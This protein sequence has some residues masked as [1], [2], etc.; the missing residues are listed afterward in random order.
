[1]RRRRI[2]QPSAVSARHRDALPC[3]GTAEQPPTAHRQSIAMPRQGIPMHRHSESNARALH[4]QATAKQGFA[5]ATRSA[6]PQG[7]RYARQ[8]RGKAMRGQDTAPPRLAMAKLR[9][10]ERWR[11]I[12]QRRFARASLRPAPQG[13]RTAMRCEGIAW[14]RTT[15]QRQGEPTPRP[16]G[17]KPGFAMPRRSDYS[18]R[19][20]HGDAAFASLW[21][22][23]PTA[24]PSSQARGPAAPT[25]ARERARPIRP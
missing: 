18:D 16:A 13:L 2:A 10:A 7:H 22:V 24:G 23:P 17:A 9:G 11:S 14:Q 25:S 21:G 6:V 8:R 4:R 3:R 19:G 20:P 12:P 1:M 5:G 15:R